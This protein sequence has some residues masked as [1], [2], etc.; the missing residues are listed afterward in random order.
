MLR[1]SL[2]FILLIFACWSPAIYAEEDAEG[3]VESSLTPSGG[4]CPNSGILSGKIMTEMCWSCF[5]HIYISG[6][7][8]EFLDIG[9]S[10]GEERPDGAYKDWLC[11]C[12]NRF[13]T[14]LGYW[15]LTYAVESVR[16][17]W[18]STMLGSTINA[19]SIG[20]AKHTSLP[21]GDN[22]STF[23][24][25]HVIAMPIEYILGLFS[26][27]SCASDGLTEI[28]FISV[29]EV[30][31]PYHDEILSFF[32]DPFAG[33]FANAAAIATSVAECAFV[34]ATNKTFSEIPFTA[35][36]WGPVYPATGFGYGGGSYVQRSKQVTMANLTWIHNVGMVK[37]SYGR[38]G[39]CG[40]G[41]DI[42]VDKEAT[43][44]SQ[45]YPVAE[46][47]RK[48]PIGTPTLKEGEWKVKSSGPDDFVQ[49]VWKY[50]DCCPRF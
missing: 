44:F 33:L 35:G 48:Y 5:E 17:D 49:F 2:L 1:S 32:S 20:F 26:S 27:F 15:K 36:C 3:D 31:A 24:N 29:S 9:S 47:K 10:G 45:F 6:N 37:K 30:I 19:D 4:A 42:T 14:P 22:D 50:R 11:E 18:C 46:T 25:A 40:K 23:R 39:I 34:G 13:G 8:V 21:S 38:R 7:K 41:R 16:K 28:D 43:M 12:D